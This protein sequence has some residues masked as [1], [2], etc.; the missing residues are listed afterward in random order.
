MPKGK[1]LSLNWG[2]RGQ[3]TVNYTGTQCFINISQPLL[4]YDYFNKLAIYI[5]LNKKITEGF[6][7]NIISEDKHKFLLHFL[8]P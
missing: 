5:L 1:K 3:W 8:I 4:N 6:V 2:E 7:L